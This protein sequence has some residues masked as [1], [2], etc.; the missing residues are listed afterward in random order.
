ML[1]GS[2]G[3]GAPAGNDGMPEPPAGIAVTLVRP[4][5]LVSTAARRRGGE[6]EEGGGQRCTRKWAC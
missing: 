6:A 5:I 4:A 3:R 1:I 2:V